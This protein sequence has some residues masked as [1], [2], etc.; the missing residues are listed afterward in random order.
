MNW[1]V[2]DLNYKGAQNSLFRNK[3]CTQAKNIST[4][5]EF[6]MSYLQIRIPKCFTDQDRILF[7]TNLGKIFKEGKNG[8]LKY[9]KT[10]AQV[11]HT[12]SKKIL[13]PNLASCY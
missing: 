7:L 8:P 10:V 12:C 6:S 9:P 1:D 3:N 4:D 2:E 5:H 11:R 13:Y